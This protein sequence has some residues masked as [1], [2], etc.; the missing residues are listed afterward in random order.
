MKGKG[1]FSV[2]LSAALILTLPSIPVFAESDTN[3][4]VQA[5]QA[6]VNYLQAIENQDTDELTKWVE[7]TRFSSLTEQEEQ[8]ENQFEND[9]F[10]DY[11][12]NDFDENGDSYEATIT[13]T[14]KA[15]GEVHSLNLPVE[16]FG[17][18]WKLVVN[19]QETMSENV[20]ARLQSNQNNEVGEISPNEI[21]PLAA[22]V[23]YWSFSFTRNGVVL[24]N[25]SAYS[26][27][28]D[29]T[30]NSV[31][32]N[33]W[34]ELPGSTR[35]V[36][37]LYSIVEKGFLGDD[38]YGETTVAGRYPQNGTWYSTSIRNEN[39]NTP[40]SDVSIKIYNPS[41]TIGPSGAGNAYQ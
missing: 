34:Q 13:M 40:P 22:A 41:S 3:D 21:K 20:K 16:K 7:D 17:D 33:G 23:A 30:G 31:T 37:L 18:Q 35:S 28:F 12:L 4:E 26:D 6:V 38:V 9:N 24:P 36:T 15:T 8:Y 1:L 5:K 39:S 2:A 10:T 27:K 29:M 25:T 19:G 14:R 11:T 32:I